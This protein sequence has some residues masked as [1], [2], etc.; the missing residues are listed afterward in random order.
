MRQG[1]LEATNGDMDLHVNRWCDT[2]WGKA[3][4]MDFRHEGTKTRRQ[5]KKYRFDR[6]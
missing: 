5:V 4:E 6:L 1:S 3:N 2:Q